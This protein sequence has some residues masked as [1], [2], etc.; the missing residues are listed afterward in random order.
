MKRYLDVVRELVSLF[1]WARK[2][3]R[4]WRPFVG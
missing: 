2:P 4:D 1:V 3:P